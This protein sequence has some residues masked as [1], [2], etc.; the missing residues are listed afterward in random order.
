MSVPAAAATFRNPG[1]EARTV[2]VSEGG[3]RRDVVI[4]AGASIETCFDGCFVLLPTGAA[5]IVRAPQAVVVEAD[6]L[7]IED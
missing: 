7:L 6:R 1:T 5:T 3:E 4:E 2:T